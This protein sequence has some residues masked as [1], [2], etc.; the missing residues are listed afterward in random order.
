[1]SFRVRTSHSGRALRSTPLYRNQLESLSGHILRSS[2]RS[3]DLLPFY[4]QYPAACCGDFLLEESISGGRKLGNVAMSGN[5]PPIIGSLLQSSTATNAERFE[6]VWRAVAPF[7][8]F[9]LRL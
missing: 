2:L 1:M 5:P 8:L 9:G 3:S 4:H 7:L 6:E